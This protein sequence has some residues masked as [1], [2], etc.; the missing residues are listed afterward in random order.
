MAAGPL[1]LGRAA[2]GPLVDV[3]APFTPLGPRS[4]ELGPSPCANAVG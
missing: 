1:A 4:T 3:R 2:L